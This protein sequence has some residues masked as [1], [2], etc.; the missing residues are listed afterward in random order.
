MLEVYVFF[1]CGYSIL[2]E[3]N[4]D[5]QKALK[6]YFLLNSFI[7]NKLYVYAL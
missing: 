2:P 7:S 3:F 1:R 5:D 4:L 6:Y